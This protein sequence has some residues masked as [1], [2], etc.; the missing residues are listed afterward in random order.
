MYDC[1]RP[2]LP[3]NVYPQT[4]L[5]VRN[6]SA[7]FGL[8]LLCIRHEPHGWRIEMSLS[9]SRRAVELLQNA[10]ANPAVR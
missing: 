4:R 1:I 3:L 2:L 9:H 10:P 7:M 5:S 8:L 6:T